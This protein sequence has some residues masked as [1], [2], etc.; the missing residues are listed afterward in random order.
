M[1]RTGSGWGCSWKKSGA[2]SPGEGTAGDLGLAEVWRVPAGASAVGDDAGR[3]EGG[4]VDAREAPLLE[5]DPDI[6][7]L[8]RGCPLGVDPEA[9]VDEPVPAWEVT[10]VA[11]AVMRAA[12]TTAV[13]LIHATLSEYSSFLRPGL[14]GISHLVNR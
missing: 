5:V 14:E 4:S 1:S 3:G 10:R 11:I 12:R 6:V 8:A 2:G 7:T 9:L 13:L